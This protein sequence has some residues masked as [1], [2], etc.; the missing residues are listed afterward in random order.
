MDEQKDEARPLITVSA[1]S[2]YW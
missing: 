2:H 1:L